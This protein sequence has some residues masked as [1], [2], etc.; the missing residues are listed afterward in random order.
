MGI[1]L[2]Q[3]SNPVD[4]SITPAGPYCVSDNAQILVAN[5]NGGM[6]S[7]AGITD[8]LNGHFDPA[9]AGAGSHII[10]YEIAGPCNSTI[11]ET[12]T[13][14]VTTSDDASWTLPPS[15]CTD[16]GPIDLDNLITGSSGGTW[17]GIG[18]TGSVFDPA[19]LSGPISITYTVGGGTC[20]GISTQDI[21][22]VAMI[23]NIQATQISCYGANDG[24]V[25]IQPSGGTT[26]THVWS[27]NSTNLAI[28]FVGAGTY[29]V[30]ITDNESGCTITDDIT[31]TEP[32]AIDLIIESSS[33]CTSSGW[34]NVLASGGSGGYTYLWTP[35][36]ETS[37][38]ISNL[39]AGNYSVTVTDGSG[40]SASA[41][42]T[43]LLASA[44]IITVNQD[45]IIS[46]GQDVPLFANGATTYS[47]FDD[48]GL[49]CY[50]C[51]DPIASPSVTTEYCAIG[52]ANGC[53][54]TACM[55]IYV[56][57]D[58]GAT[59]VPSAFSP[60]DDGENDL[61]CVYNDCLEQV[62]FIIYNR[63]GEKVYETGS[64]T[65]C[66]DGTWKG[67]TL[68]SAVFIYVL[69][70]TNYGGQTILKKG[71]ISLIR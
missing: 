37:Q 50:D 54:D 59:F 15:Q 39:A 11:T 19:G 1:D 18:V 22:V 68:N 49:D 47:W 52:F 51:Q 26:Y 32:P 38:Q 46:L 21:N 62:E 25:Q 43:I 67:K 13:I 9:V 41:D 36:G 45:T 34:A 63:W 8:P 69:K 31:I 30:L 35:N 10:S 6:W 70:G 48:P 3:F 12:I 17:S 5:T 23:S 4:A 65:I 27:D 2:I 14:D 60:N 55:K 16:G 24:M 58:C 42:A 44:P 56:N 40:C 7:G 64:T 57:Y 66:W 33:G 20:I 29:S 61:L 53:A 28:T 71:N